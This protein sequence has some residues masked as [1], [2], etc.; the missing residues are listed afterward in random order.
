MLQPSSTEDL[1]LNPPSDTV[2]VPC[3]SQK[4]IPFSANS[5][6]CTVKP[7]ALWHF[8][9]AASNPRTNLYHPATLTTDILPA[10][11]LFSLPDVRTNKL[12][13][14][15]NNICQDPLENFFG[16]QRQ[17]GSTSDNPNVSE[18]MKNTATLRV[19]NSFCRG[20]RTGNCCRGTSSSRQLITEKENTPL[21]R[22]HK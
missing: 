16:V 9:I 5:V 21:Q 13:F 2:G 20:P 14:L 18:F 19:V 8:V 6:S 3:F 4:V 22:R 11:Y 12:A 15:S 1:C 10:Q 17:R 7:C